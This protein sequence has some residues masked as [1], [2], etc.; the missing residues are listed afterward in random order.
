M[1]KKQAKKPEIPSDPIIKIYNHVFYL[2]QYLRSVSA[3]KLNPPTEYERTV[4]GELTWTKPSVERCWQEFDCYMKMYFDTYKAFTPILVEIRELR[5]DP[6][7]CDMVFRTFEGRERESAYLDEAIDFIE[8]G[9]HLFRRLIE[10]GGYV[11]ERTE[12]V[13]YRQASVCSRI[14]RD[15][16]YTP[17]EITTLEAG[18][19]WES[20]WI[21]NRRNPLQATSTT[22]FEDKPPKKDTPPSR[23]KIRLWN[24]YIAFLK[25]YLRWQEEYETRTGRKRSSPR[26]WL[27]EKKTWP[28]PAQAFFKGLCGSKDVES[29]D[30]AVDRAIRYARQLEKEKASWET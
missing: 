28:K 26:D 3:S 12:K 9:F 24:R 23:E 6:I 2:L 20:A 27:L 18:L 30:K 5:R 21:H 14:W 22:T 16:D 15:H 4:D 11:E 7:V 1:K 17:S 25:T 19:K 29:E 8:R 13:F 10:E